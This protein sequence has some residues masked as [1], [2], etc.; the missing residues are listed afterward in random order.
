MDS[1]MEKK[2]IKDEDEYEKWVQ[3]HYILLDHGAKDE[4]HPLAEVLD[5]LGGVIKEYEMSKYNSFINNSIK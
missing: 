3:A 5:L 4:S 2:M 1:E